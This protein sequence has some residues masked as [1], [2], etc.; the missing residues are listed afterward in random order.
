MAV[1]R[2]KQI[3]DAA[4]KSFTMFGYKATTMDQVAKIANVGKGTIYTFFKNKEELFSEIITGL[5]QEMKEAADECFDP[6]NRFM[7]NLHTTLMKMLEFRRQHQLTI[8]LFQEQKEMGTLEVKEV[9]DRLENAVI[10]YI[11]MRVQEAIDKGEVQQCDTELIAFLIFKLY[12]ALIF[13]WERNHSPLSAEEIAVF[14]E[15]TLF[16]GLSI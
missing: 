5:I 10:H 1:D 9:I 6:S 12:L 16:K 4:A 8:K 15:N 7:E 3:I 2:K 11:K 14:F 13:D